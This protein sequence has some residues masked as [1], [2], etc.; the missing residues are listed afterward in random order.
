M[1][2]LHFLFE[3]QKVIK[4]RLSVVKL[5]LQQQRVTDTQDLQL[6]LQGYKIQP[7]I[8]EDSAFIHKSVIQLPVGLKFKIK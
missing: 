1:T 3:L 5:L 4:L 2:H 7:Y 6:L 8:S